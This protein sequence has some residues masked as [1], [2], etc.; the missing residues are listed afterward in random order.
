MNKIMAEFNL[1][2]NSYRETYDQ[3]AYICHLC[4][5]QVEKYEKSKREMESNWQSFVIKFCNLTSWS[6]L[7]VGKDN[8]N[9]HRMQT[10]DVAQH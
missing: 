8:R 1:S 9:H 4:T 2:I 10:S 3:D 6:L 7:L 5:S